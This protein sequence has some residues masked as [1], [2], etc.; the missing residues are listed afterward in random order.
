MSRRGEGSGVRPIVLFITV[1][2]TIG[3]TEKK[4]AAEVSN[5]E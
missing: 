5:Q 1:L 3:L 2:E 4:E